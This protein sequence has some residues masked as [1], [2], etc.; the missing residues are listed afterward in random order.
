MISVGDNDVFISKI[1][2]AGNF[3]WSKQ[4]G[5]IDEG[6]SFSIALDPTKNVYTTGYFYGTN[7]LVQVAA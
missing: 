5:G 3:I 2:V 7:G 6:Y 4:F 1:D